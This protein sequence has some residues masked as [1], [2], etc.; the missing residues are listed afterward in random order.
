MAGRYQVDITMASKTEYLVFDFESYYSDRYSLGKMSVE[1]YCLDPRFQIIAVAV[2][3]LDE[4]LN[5]LSAD[6]WTGLSR[7]ELGD[8]LAL[9]RASHIGSAWVAHNAWFDGFILERVLDVRPRRLLCTAALSNWTGHSRLY[10]RSLKSLC[11]GLG[12]GEKGGDREAAVGRR[13]EDFSPEELKRYGEYCAND[14]LLCA[15]LLRSFLPLCPPEALEMVDMSV[16][17]YTS[18]KLVLDVPKLAEYRD[19]CLARQDADRERLR[20]LFDF[21]DRESFLKALRSR[22]RFVKMLK[23][24]GAEV[25][26]KRSAAKVDAITAALTVK[27]DCMARIAAGTFN[28]ADWPV[29]EKASRL[30]ERGA[31]T[32]A[33]AKDDPGFMALMESRDE[34]VALLC[35]LRAGNNTSLAVSRAETLLDIAA[36]GGGRLPIPLMPWGSLTGRY[37]GSL[38]RDASDRVNLQNLPKHG[39]D[40]VIRK[41]ICAPAGTLIVAGDSAQIEARCGAFVAGERGLLNVFRQGRDPYIR[42][43]AVIEGLSE[44]E[45]ACGVKDGDPRYKAMRAVGKVTILSSQYG[46]GPERLALYFTRAGIALAPDKFAH[47]ERAREIHA[48]YNDR[49]DAIRDYRSYCQRTVEKMCAMKPGEVFRMRP[50]MKLGKTAD[51]AA[52]L[53]LPSGFTLVYPK[54]RAGKGGHVYDQWIGARKSEKGIYGGQL[55]NNIVQALSFHVLWLQGVIINRKYQVVSNIHDSWIAVCRLEDAAD[56]REHVLETLRTP[57]CEWASDLPLNAEVKVSDTYEIA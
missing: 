36:R 51:G 50:F 6:V 41:C 18:P 49:H 10:G 53:H 37:T 29:L 22:D 47:E 12:L 45:I 2:R 54:L 15:G 38:G 4:D 55:F 39:D 27:N 19:S 21:P 56:A 9:E 46:I 34:N 20:R 30:L 1:S 26:V 24:L 57:P 44:D 8:L 14:T 25:P 32:P 31:E 28:P 13:L 16:R 48:L 11:A 17:M 3:R 52:L 23:S 40:A 5:E 42:M 43:A 7:K 33:L 35:K